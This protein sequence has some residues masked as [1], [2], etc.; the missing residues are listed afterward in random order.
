MQ[1]TTPPTVIT[2]RLPPHGTVSGSGAFGGEGQLIAIK[3]SCA[4]ST[5]VCGHESR[6]RRWGCSRSAR[7]A[8]FGLT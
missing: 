3:A 6:S 4:R 7:T 2:L 5:D 1:I 8:T